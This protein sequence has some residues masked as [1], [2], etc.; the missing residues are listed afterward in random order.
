MEK[1]EKPSELSMTINLFRLN[2]NKGFVIFTTTPLA[3]SVGK[4]MIHE[5]MPW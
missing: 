5:A 3:V 1:R 4:Q 2:A